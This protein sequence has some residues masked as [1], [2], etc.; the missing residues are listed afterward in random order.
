MGEICRLC[1]NRSRGDNCERLRPG[2]RKVEHWCLADVPL[3]VRLIV[4][5]VYLAWIAKYIL[6]GHD[7]AFYE[8]VMA[9]NKESVK[10][11]V[12]CE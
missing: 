9:H 5:P 3:W 10:E 8:K 1:G 2:I 6:T 7:I 12:G 11:E 4:M